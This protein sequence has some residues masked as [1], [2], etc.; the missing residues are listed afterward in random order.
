VVPLFEKLLSA[1]DADLAL[2]R[3]VIPTK[4]AETFFPD[5]SESRGVHLKI[6]DTKGKEWDFRYRSLPSHDG[7]VYVLEELRDFMISMK[8]QA[9]DVVTFYRL[10]P[11][12]KLVMGLRKSSAHPIVHE[13]SP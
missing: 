12:R 1:T 13:I 6:R 5:V 4:C 11:E 3:L 7:K 8:W 2:A 10:E 9:G